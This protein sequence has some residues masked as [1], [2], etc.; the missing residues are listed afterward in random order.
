MSSPH[1]LVF[2]EKATVYEE[3]VQVL[4]A[5]I[6]AVHLATLT[7]L[8]D[9]LPAPEAALVLLH[10]SAAN[11]AEALTLVDERAAD[12][13]LVIIASEIPTI[14]QFNALLEHDVQ[15]LIQYPFQVEQVQETLDY[16]LE[17]AQRQAT[18]RHFK[19]SAASRVT[20]ANQQLNQR[21]Q[22]INAIYT[23]G[24]SVTSSLDVEEI[25]ARIIEA[26]VNLTQAEEGF[27]LLTD[28]GKLYLRVS[29]NMN[30]ELA[31]RL[32]VEAS[33]PIARQV[34]LSGRPT[35]LNRS[36]RIA[37]GYLVRALLYV[38]IQSPGRGTIGV[39]SVVNLESEQAFTE[40]QLFTLS[41]IA[42]FAAIALE[43]A[44]LFAAVEAERSRLS[45]ILEHAAE[46][47]LVTD[48]DNRLWLWSDSAAENFD[49]KSGVRGQKVVEHIENMGIR[50]L[51]ARLGEDQTLVHNE[52]DLEDG[53]VFNAQLSSI[54]HIGRVV[55]MQDITHL[56]EL[57]RLK[58]EFVST[59]SHDLRTPLT[60]IQGYIEL[61]ERAGPLSDGQRDF[62]EKA[63][64]SLSH[65]TALISDLLD[66]GRIEAG[67]DLDMQHFCLNDVI[68]ESV[69][70]HMIYIEQA[71]LYI[72]TDI[73][74]A[75]LWIYGNSRR[76]RQVLDNLVSNAIKYSRPGGEVKVTAQ[77][78]A[79]YVIVSIEDQG[80][81]IPLEEQPKL[82]ER[83][84]RVRTPEMEAFHG[85]GLG[86]SIVKSVIEKHKGRVWVRSYPG[87][88]STFAFILT[89]CPPPAEESAEA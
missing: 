35:M 19:E 66:I 63:M 86:L 31:Q 54:N 9:A 7:E 48:L 57:D 42:D 53:R 68:Q 1:I 33:D 2:S 60:T 43:N 80:I 77:P 14:A 50:E 39:L 85:T 34:I 11:G 52:V 38:P 82:F 3:L 10:L 24:K 32:C 18:Q 27:I 28:N 49:I 61:L 16:A 6:K 76:I 73:P 37:T 40:N 89:L 26:S 69:D 20:H 47:I 36:T 72:M 4:P 84:Y 30:A 5:E 25:L 8:R 65:I 59:V 46:A 88:G 22:E 62:I 51:F 13:S 21:L 70:A 41:A 12:A 15:A 58:S 64:H 79:D 55:V 71:E 81:G 56:K 75:A 45:A 78:G 74:D 23:V 17:R 29:K 44:Q 87:Q 67:Y 83:F